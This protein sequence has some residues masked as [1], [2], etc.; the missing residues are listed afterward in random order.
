MAP[1]AEGFADLTR[2]TSAVSAVSTVTDLGADQRKTPGWFAR[3]RRSL[4]WNR[5]S[6]WERRAAETDLLAATGVPLTI[7]DVKV[8]PGKEDYMHT[9]VG[10]D[11]AA[12]PAVV[13]HGYAA[14]AGF[15]FKSIRDLVSHF[16]V[17]LVDWPGYGV[18]GRP[19]WRTKGRENVERYFV[20][21][22]ETWRKDAGLEQFVLVA[23]S[24]GG[25]LG[26][27]YAMQH[28]E[29][30]SHLVLVGPAGMNAAPE[31]WSVDKV[32]ERL[33]AKPW[34]MRSILIDASVKLWDWGVTP[35]HIIRTLGPLGRRMVEGYVSRRFSQYGTGLTPEDV[36]V[37][38]HYVYH[39]L[40]A[41]G[42]G[43]H[44]LRH[45]LAPFAWARSPIGPELAKLRM[46]VTFI[47]GEG[48]WM[49]PA[50]GKKHCE[51]A[52][53][54]RPPLN[55][56]DLKVELVKHAGHFPFIENSDG[57]RAALLRSLR[58]DFAEGDS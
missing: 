17:H 31:D 8:G 43:E 20:D 57:F 6:E 15:Y 5:T 58:V 45:L 7:K 56:A 37:F 2:D 44:A 4:A 27:R 29:R 42:S 52:R 41:P 19:A 13:V 38:K 36:E 22:L 14:G 35:G 51:A 55:D 34:S 26:V 10:G 11:S 3:M 23:H 1:T 32:K 25:Y 18:S 46:P 28:P 30:V 9:I 33:K 12:P 21:G 39:I 24:L 54:K 49:D 48:D 16:R 40:A 53:E 47:Y 50:S